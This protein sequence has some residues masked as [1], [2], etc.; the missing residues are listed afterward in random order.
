LPRF[1]PGGNFS[2]SGVPLKF[3]IATAWNVGFQS[4]RLTGGPD[5]VNSIDSAYDIEAK[6]P[7]GAFPPGMPSNGRAEKMRQMLQALLEDR[8]Q[9][10][11][12]AESRE[13]PLY[14]VVVA[15]GGLKLEKSDFDEQNCPRLTEPGTGCHELMGGRGR[16]LHGKAVS[17]ADVLG[18]V[19]NWTDRPLLDQTGIQGLFKIEIRG[20]RDVQPAQEPAPGTKAENGQD[21][22]DL[23]TLFE[24]IDRLGLKLQSQKGAA[25]IFVIEHVERPTG[26]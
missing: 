1:G 2:V 15:K 9:L 7:E 17:I 22:A 20:W 24:V 23:P 14:A 8:F 12:R 13:L 3:V 16:G 10:K 21:A 26:N 4:V 5:W 11:I 19:E 25:Q 18:Y 6:A